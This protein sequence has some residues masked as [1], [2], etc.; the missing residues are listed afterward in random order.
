MGK[1]GRHVRVTGDF[2]GGNPK[3]PSRIRH[4]G[5]DVFTVVPTWEDDA[6]RLYGLRLAVMVEN[7]RGTST[8]VA[9]NVDWGTAEHM[10]YKDVYYLN[11]EGDEDWTA[12]T[13]SLRGQV[14]AL[15]FEAGPGT[16]YLGLFPMYNYSRYLAFTDA[17]GQRSEATV[18]LAG[19]SRQG[20]EIWRVQIPAEPAAGAEPVVFLCR[21]NA[22]ESAGNFMIEGM[23]R[24]LFSGEPEAL[25]L[26]RH[27]VFHLLP[28]SN[29]DGVFDGLE[30]DTA[31]EDGAN[32]G[33]M[34]TAPDPAHQAIRSTLEAVQPKLFV[35]LHNWMIPDVDGL[36]CNDELYA[37]RLAELLPHFGELP[38]RYHRE[39]YAEEGTEVEDRGD[40]TVC[41]VSKLAE[42][43][44][45]S[46]GTWKDFCRE[47]FDARAM[48][49][50]F[51][52]R[53][54]TV[55]DMRQIGIAVLKALCLIRLG[56][57]NPY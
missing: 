18:K 36:L 4:E 56:E 50:E 51:P 34:N 31:L 53:G 33:R 28:M 54:R 35:N 38:R 45:H 49:L 26:M 20:R 32:L 17:L 41:P 10:E 42:L 6:S 9:V 44:K 40:V 1:S 55:D 2:D 22:C 19:K 37:R 48:A 8:A 47:R 25:E 57:R 16:S 39:W 27:F 43:H 5:H 7:P 12:V 14:A 11:A 23:V 21:N 15:E 46:G 29:P 13:A 30:R 24:F 3:D 52:W